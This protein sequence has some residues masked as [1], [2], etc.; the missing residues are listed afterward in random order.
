MADKQ[1]G[2]YTTTATNM[3]NTVA[4]YDFGT[5]G[6]IKGG[7]FYVAVNPSY[8]APA[9][10]RVFA[11]YVTDATQR[12]RWMTILDKNYE[13]LAMVQNAT[14]GPRA[15]LV[16]GSRHQH[17]LRLRRHAHAVS[18][19]ARRL[20][21]QRPAREGVLRRRSARSSRASAPPTS[22]TATASTGMPT[23]SN[24]NSTFIGPAGAA[25]M[26]SNQ[27]QLVADAYTRVAADARAAN[28]QLLRPFVGAVH[29]HADDRQLRQFSIALTC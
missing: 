1:W 27:P 18:R 19:R 20:L 10:Y 12:A 15:R 5:D 17:E 4:M 21:E 13:I 7:D 11:A 23:G 14:I 3:L 8:I 24:K 29:G 9:F 25:G 28:D 22:S 2:G 26:A 16:G 6:T